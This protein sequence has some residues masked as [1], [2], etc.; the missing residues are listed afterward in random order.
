VG[1]S[2]SGDW[3]I[4]PL[5][6]A[7]NFQEG[8]IVLN[9]LREQISKMMLVDPFETPGA[10]S[11]TATEVSLQANLTVETASPSIARIQYE[12]VKHLAD[13]GIEILRRKGLWGDDVID[14]KRMAI[15]YQLPTEASQGIKN[16]K[17]LMNLDG[18]L[19]QMVGPE[20]SAGCYNL[21]ELPRW[22]AEQLGAQLNLVKTKNEMQEAGEQAKEQA[23]QQQQLMEQQMMQQGAR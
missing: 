9:D 3:P 21:D 5:T 18:V 10:P 11:K 4:Q 13:R 20:M 22:V 14:N 12:A 2:V 16:V 6:P 19:K 17:T 23:D 15:R 7:G 1:Q 8:A